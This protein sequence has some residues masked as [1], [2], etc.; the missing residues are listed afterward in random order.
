MPHSR[1]EENSIKVTG[2]GK[3]RRMIWSK[4]KEDYGIIRKIICVEE[5]SEEFS[6][7]SLQMKNSESDHKS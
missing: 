7:E 6:E 3:K 2:G 4:K 5:T 1:K